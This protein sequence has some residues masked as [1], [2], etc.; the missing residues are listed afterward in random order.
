MSLPISGFTAVPNPQMLAFMGAQSF[1]MMYQAGEGWQYGKRRIS[2]MSNEEFNELTPELVLEKQAIVL[3]N[4]LKTIEQS[5]NNMTPMIET[6][7]K[8][9]GEFLRIVI[10][11]TPQALATG[12]SG[13]TD[14]TT[15]GHEHEDTLGAIVDHLKKLVP[16]L[17]EA[18]ARRG[19]EGLADAIETFK[20]TPNPKGT[21]PPTPSPAPRVPFTNIPL[22]ERRRVLK[23]AVFNEQ[24]L[25]KVLI[26]RKARVQMILSGQLGNYRNTPKLGN[27]IG[28]LNFYIAKYTP[29][30]AQMR[31]TIVLLKTAVRLGEL[32]A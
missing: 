19:A 13:I 1:I 7:I 4:S 5:M 10:K 3:K 12:F 24:D 15:G 26:A 11:E 30:L 21:Q 2:A 27:E 9:Y 6:I 32:A 14:P 23:E 28:T 20:P 22:E 31:R 16:S 18:E 8:Q 29:I 25:N 17:P